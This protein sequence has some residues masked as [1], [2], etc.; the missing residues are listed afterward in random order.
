MNKV[1]Y[2]HKDSDLRGQFTSYDFTW[3]YQEYKGLKKD[4]KPCI[5]FPFVHNY[6]PTLSPGEKH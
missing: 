3:G 5:I 6:V 2:N 4:F 1:D